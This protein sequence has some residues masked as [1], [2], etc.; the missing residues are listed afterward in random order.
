LRSAA[1]QVTMEDIR[2]I[3]TDLD[4]TLIGSVDEFPLYSQFRQRLHAYR[5]ENGT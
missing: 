3:A 5:R 2:L 4:G 1:D